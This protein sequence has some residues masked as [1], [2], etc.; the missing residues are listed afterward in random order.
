MVETYAA[1]AAESAEEV[2]SVLMYNRSGARGLAIIQMAR[3]GKLDPPQ[4]FACVRVETTIDVML[5]FEVA[6]GENKVISV[7]T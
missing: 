3:S 2:S 4:Q 5:I 6:L 1:Q 7:E